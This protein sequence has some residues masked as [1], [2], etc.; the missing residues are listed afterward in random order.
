MRV[1]AF[2]QIAQAYGVNGK[3]KTNA[4]TKVRQSDK[5]E[6]SSFGKEMH[7][8]RQAVRE[9]SDIREDKV[10]ELKAK[11]ESGE[12][13]VSAESFADKLIAKYEELR[14]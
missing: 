1:D 3:L 9:T 13:N 14:G 10:A 6:I 5:V 12:Y 11:I 4:V 8:A 2:D 7:I